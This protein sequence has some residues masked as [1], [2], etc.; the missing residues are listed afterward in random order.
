MERRWCTACGSPFM[1]R[2]HTPHQSY[3]SLDACQRERKRL[4]Q[5][6]KRKS[7]PDYLDNQIVAQRVCAD[8]VLTHRLPISI[9][10]PIGKTHSWQQFPTPATGSADFGIMGQLAVR[11]DNAAR[12]ARRI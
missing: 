6:I 3:C 8:N 10:P 5:Q 4:W 9:D 11:N 12:K 2:A 1:P 7:D